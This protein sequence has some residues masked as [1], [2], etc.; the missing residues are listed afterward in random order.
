MSVTETL[1]YGPIINFE[2][3]LQGSLSLKSLTC[4]LNSW[5]PLDR[6]EKENSYRDG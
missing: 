6:G 5:W 3:S 1:H 2:K 4:V